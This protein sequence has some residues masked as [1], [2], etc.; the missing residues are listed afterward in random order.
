MGKRIKPTVVPSCRTSDVRGGSDRVQRSRGLD[1][2]A[3]EDCLG[4][5]RL[6]QIFELLDDDEQALSFL[7]IGCGDAQALRELSRRYRQNGHSFYGLDPLR[8]SLIEGFKFL[9]GKIEDVELGCER[10]DVITSVTALLYC[11]DIKTALQKIAR[12]LKP[13]GIA[14]IDIDSLYLGPHPFSMFDDPSVARWSDDKQVL[15]VYPSDGSTIM[16]GYAMRNLPSELCSRLYSWPS[17]AEYEIPLFYDKRV[18]IEM[19]GRAK[20]MEE[21]KGGERRL[22]YLNQEVINWSVRYFLQTRKRNS[23][24]TPGAQVVN[25]IGLSVELLYLFVYLR[26]LH[27][28]AIRK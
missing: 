12:A 17:G 5:E 20:D 4:E 3:R 26:V 18:A 25:I 6:A 9:E 14:F 28:R 16:Q 24:G 1:E 23:Y 2:W 10:F 13:G 19:Q 21:M 22:T 8:P 15:I 27:V 11:N 7:E